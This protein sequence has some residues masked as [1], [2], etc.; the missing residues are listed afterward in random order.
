MTR[1]TKEDLL[2]LMEENVDA[3]YTLPHYGLIADWYRRY[4]ELHMMLK[5]YFENDER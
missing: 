1:P 4:W 3:H 5:L 2:E